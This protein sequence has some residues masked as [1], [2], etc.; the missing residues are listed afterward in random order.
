MPTQA[1]L[2]NI[3]CGTPSYFVL[4]LE[5]T[6]VQNKIIDME[7]QDKVLIYNKASK[8][9]FILDAMTKTEFVIL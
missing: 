5:I 6:P 8:K 2:L 1:Y 4:Y 7:C 3:Q 9:F